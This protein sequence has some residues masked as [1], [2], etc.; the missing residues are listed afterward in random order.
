MSLDPWL[1]GSNDTV[2][3]QVRAYVGSLVNA[4][5]GTSIEDEGR[6]IL[7]DDT[8]GK[9]L[10]KTLKDSLGN[11]ATILQTV[12]KH[13]MISTSFTQQNPALQLNNSTTRRKTHPSLSIFLH[14]S[15][16]FLLHLTTQNKYENN[17]IY[18]DPSLCYAQHLVSEKKRNKSIKH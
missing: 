9:S 11:L 12:Q 6:Y 8:N 4:V 7:G 18:A 14:T 10:K 17:Y 13:S 1:D 5:G 2:D 15:N 3:P 16:H